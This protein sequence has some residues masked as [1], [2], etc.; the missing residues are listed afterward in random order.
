MQTTYSFIYQEIRKSESLYNTFKFFWK[1]RSKKACDF[2][3]IID[4]ELMV[5]LTS[6]AN[7]NVR[8]MV[9]VST[10]KF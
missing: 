6:S 4:E 2:L 7:N 9:S 10:D 8:S 5:Y 3:K 1:G